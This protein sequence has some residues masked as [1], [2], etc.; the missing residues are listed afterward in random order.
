MG[1][2]TRLRKTCPNQSKERW[3]TTAQYGSAEVRILHLKAG[4]KKIVGKDQG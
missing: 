3:M 2:R 1:P 4:G